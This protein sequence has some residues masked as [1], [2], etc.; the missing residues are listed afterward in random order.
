MRYLGRAAE[1]K[2][3]NRILDD[4]IGIGDPLMLAQVLHPGFDQERFHDAPFIC[5]VVED[6][7]RI[8]SVAAPLM[9]EPCQRFEERGSVLG[10]DAIFDC[11]QTGPRSSLMACLVIGAG[12]C[13]DG[14]RS[15]PAP[16]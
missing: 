8:S 12:Q 3:V 1:M 7:P 14:V 11:D 13:I 9:L 5:S 15:T 16:V 2:T 4:A 10:I 6:A